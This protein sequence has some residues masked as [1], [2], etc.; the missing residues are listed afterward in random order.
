MVEVRLEQLDAN[1]EYS[2]LVKWNYSDLAAV[3]LDDMI[4]MVET[5]KA[6]VDILSPASGFLVQGLAEGDALV[7]GDLI[8]VVAESEEE[9]RTI[10]KELRSQDKKRKKSAQ[11]A[12]D[13]EENPASTALNITKKAKD[14]LNANNISPDVFKGMALV[15]ERDVKEY[16]TKNTK[17][18]PSAPIVP[19]GK[20]NRVL[21]L[22]ARVGGMQVLDILLNDPSVSVVGFVDDD[23]ELSD[24][25]VWDVPV[26]GT[27]KEIE[28]LWKR[29]LFDSAII[30]FSSNIETRKELFERCVS[31]GIPMANAIDPS[32]RINRACSL[33]QGNI[34]CSHVH[35]GF[36]SVL[37]NNNF[38]GANSSIDHDNKMG[39]HVLMGPNCVTSGR[40]EV[41]NEVRFGTGIFVQPQL[42]IGAGSIISSGSVLTSSVPA[43]HVVKVNY[44]Q[45]M[46]PK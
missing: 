40:V 7:T 43:N 31:L 26:L 14:L 33:G 42:T 10:Q 35:I 15:T 16:I 37:G 38:I 28:S 25:Q 41:G 5:S 46:G 8:A 9:A 23:P 30:G 45:R 6:V 13:A 17:L 12:H 34:I 3:S 44:S 4:C 22:T 21:I 36:G 24:S 18:A 27:F 2:V 20:T 29:D 39:D 11:A 1:S 19:S 32:V